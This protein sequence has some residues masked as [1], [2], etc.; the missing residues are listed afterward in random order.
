M[1][2]TIDGTAIIYC[3]GALNTPNGKTAHG[4][5]RFTNRYR[6]IAVIDSRYTGQDAG[7]IID[8]KPN[9]ISVE[10]TV[11]DA[12]NSANSAGTP[13]THLV[14]GLAPDGGLLAPTARLDIK[15][16]LE[17]GLNVD[18]GLHDFLSE[19]TELADT[20]V[21]SVVLRNGILYPNK[22]PGLG[23]KVCRS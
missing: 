9:G 20:A 11:E 2:T 19:D 4:L 12:V 7:K 15:R 21:G 8:D 22:K 14:V 13:A 10:A 1:T 17:L 3:E 18:S 5:V 16:A 6:V 23:A